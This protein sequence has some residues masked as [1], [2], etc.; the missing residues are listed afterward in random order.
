MR[1][2]RRNSSSRPA[3]EAEVDDIISIFELLDNTNLL[4]DYTFAAVNHE[5]LLKY[6]PEEVN[7]C[8]VADKQVRLDAT[9]AQ[10]TTR[11]D[12]VTCGNQYPTTVN[13]VLTDALSR[14]EASVVEST[15]S[16]R[17]Q[18]TQLHAICDSMSSTN[19]MQAPAQ[20]QSNVIY[21]RQ[22]HHDRS[23]NVIINGIAEV[24][25]ESTWRAQVD[26]ALKTAAGREVSVNDV[27]RLGKYSTNRI[28]P[29]IV[30]L[31]SAWDRRVILNGARKLAGVEQL[32]RVFISPDD[33][34]EVRRKKN[35]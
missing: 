1:A 19:Q 25:E 6:G 22:E 34:L 13:T 3:H 18:I 5:R 35:T 27:F 20:K 9:M 14:V 4:Q 7:I 12:E 17:D 23:R 28:R 10:L 15:R 26:E 2:D 32:A 21:T 31:H 24:R 29:L 33:P 30:K 8:T 16:L 11:L